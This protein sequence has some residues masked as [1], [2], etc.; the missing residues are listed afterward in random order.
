[1]AARDLEPLRTNA[2]RQSDLS[3]FDRCALSASWERALRNQNWATHPQARGSLVHRVLGKCL[4]DMVRMHEGSIPVD[5]ALAILHETLRQHDVPPAELLNVPMNE[6]KDLY[7]VVKKW[8]HDF[9]WSVENLVAIE[10]RLYAPVVYPDA[11]GDPV[12]RAMTGQIDALFVEGADHAIVLDW[13]DTWGLPAATEVSHK[14]YFQQRFYGFLVMITYPTIMRVTLREVYLRYSEV[15]EA[16]LHREDIDDV[17]AELTALVE[18]YDRAF[19]TKTFPPSPGHHCGYCLRPE[20]CPIPVKLRREGKIDSADEAAIVARQ[21]VVGNAVAKQSRAALAAW[22]DSNGPVPIKD[23]KGPRVY[24]YV[25]AEQTRR[26]DREALERA[27]AAGDVDVD[28]LY[29]TVLT[30]RFVEHV[31]RKDR[32]TDEDVVLM[33]ALEGALAEAQARKGNGDG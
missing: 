25:A 12:E 20:R 15:R 27:L 21:L 2:I 11:N 10:E 18:R 23:A 33:A 9:E 29:R 22:A 14:G 4:R 32:A 31:P 17:R 28:K 8:A 6:V 3:A 24:G 26:P 1:M 13:K 5:A 7:W 30:A 19:A 16:T